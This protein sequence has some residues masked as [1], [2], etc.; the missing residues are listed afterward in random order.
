MRASREE[1][2][3]EWRRNMVV[4]NEFR[5][6]ILVHARAKDNQ[7]YTIIHNSFKR[8]LQG[9]GDQQVNI[10]ALDIIKAK[11]FNPRVINAEYT[12]AVLSAELDL[13]NSEVNE[14]PVTYK[15]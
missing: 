11:G 14:E 4:F 3:E 15:I 2:I 9:F 7:D 1:L 5:K 10:L 12:Q 8:V 6:D 13:I